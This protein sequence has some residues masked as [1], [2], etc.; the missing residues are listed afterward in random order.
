MKRVIC[1]FVAAA[2]AGT[3]AGCETAYYERT[4]YASGYVPADYGY[5][6]SRSYSPSRTY[7][8]RWDYYRHYNGID[9]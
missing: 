4:Q 2:L 8:S 9:G 6:P 5:Y 1:L 7:S 3:L